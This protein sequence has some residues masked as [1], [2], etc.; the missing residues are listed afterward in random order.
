[1]RGQRGSRQACDGVARAQRERQCLPF[2]SAAE[3]LGRVGAGVSL[4]RVRAARMLLHEGGDVVNDAVDGEPV[5][6]LGVVVRDELRNRTRSPLLLASRRLALGLDLLEGASL[7][8]AV[9][10]RS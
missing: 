6:A 4:K 1:M 8:S 2:V 10:A 9:E 3:C 7:E 5:A